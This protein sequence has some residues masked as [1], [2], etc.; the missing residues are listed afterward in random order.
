MTVYL[1]EPE[2]LIEFVEGL[3][4]SAGASHALAHAQ[5]N[6]HWL[7]IRDLLES[8]IEKGQVLATSKSMPRSQLLQELNLRSNVEGKR[9]N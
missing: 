1:T 8:L 6:T 7:K 3:K 4:R 5:Q 9:I 2:I